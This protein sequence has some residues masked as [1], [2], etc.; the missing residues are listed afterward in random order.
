M[1]KEKAAVLSA[2]AMGDERFAGAMSIAAQ[3]TRSIMCVPL[4]HGNDLLGLIHLDSRAAIDAFTEKD[5]L[6]LTSIARQAALS[7]ANARMAKRIEEQDVRRDRL[8]RYFAEG[9]IADILA[10]NE[11]MRLGGHSHLITLLFTD[12]RGFTSMMERL[13]AE[14]AVEDVTRAGSPEGKVGAD[15]DLP[16]DRT[17]L[18][19]AAADSAI[20][21][22]L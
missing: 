6:I 9:V 18:N 7:I 16:R 21:Q 19:I 17:A 13:P 15:P 14:S 8:S 2:D 11:S 1:L 3:G 22:R 12:I 20:P 5:L 4:L 10:G